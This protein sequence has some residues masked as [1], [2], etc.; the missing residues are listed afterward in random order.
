[1]SVKLYQL[2]CDV[3]SWKRITDGSDVKDLHEYK[4]SAIQ[5]HIPKLDP[6][7]KKVVNSKFRNPPRKFRCP[8]CGRPVIAR[9]IAN[10]QAVVDQ[11][12][13]DS[14]RSEMVEAAEREQEK[15]LL[16]AI[17]ESEEQA[18]ERRKEVEKKRNPFD[19]S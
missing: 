14:K 15:N 18:A 1:M 8:S 3:C 17:K 2:F 6:V 19:G 16:D 11:M 4:T 12:I 7:T 13:E 9:K 5:K 10:S